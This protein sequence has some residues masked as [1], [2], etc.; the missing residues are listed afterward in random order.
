MRELAALNGSASGMGLGCPQNL[1]QHHK[2]VQRLCGCAE[3][4]LTASSS[5]IRAKKL[6]PRSS[7]SSFESATMI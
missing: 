6:A 1:P 3:T 4:A 7:P 5:L 2:L